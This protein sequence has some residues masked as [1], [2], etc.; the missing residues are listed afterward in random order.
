MNQVN[1]A[2]IV[3]SLREENSVLRNEIST[4]QEKNLILQQEITDFKSSKLYYQSGW[5]EDDFSKIYIDRNHN[6]FLLPVPP[7]F[8]F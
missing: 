4:L 6:V 8:C 5:L 3:E 2:T 7:N 1:A